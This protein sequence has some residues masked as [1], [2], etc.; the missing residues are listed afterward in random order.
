MPFITTTKT[1]VGLLL[2]VL[3]YLLLSFSTV[4]YLQSS[5]SRNHEAEELEKLAQ[6]L[7]LIRANIEAEVNAELFLADSMATLITFA[8]NAGPTQWEQVAK[9]LVRKGEH[10]RNISVAPND[11]IA[12][13]YPLAGNER[14]IGLD[15]HDNPMQWASIVQARQSQR[16]SISGPLLLVQGG[17][18][19]IGRMPLYFDPPFNTQYWGHCS[20]VIDINGLFKDAGV[21]ELPDNIQIAIRGLNATGASGPV[22]LGDARVFDDP[23]VTESVNLVSGSWLLGL[24]HLDKHQTRPLSKW[25]KDNI[26][27]VAGYC[28][29]ISFLISFIFIYQAYR[30]ANQI[31]LQ[32]V[33][34]KLPNRRYAMMVL[35]QLT[36]AGGR[37]TIINIDLNRFK[38]VN[39]TLGH[40]AGDA[41]LIEVAQ[42]LKQSLRG[43]D[44]VARLGGDEFLIILPRVYSMTE[45]ELVRQKLEQ[46]CL[47]PFTYETTPIEVSLSF[48]VACYP[49]DARDISELLHAADQAMYSEKQRKKS[50]QL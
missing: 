28:I 45:I 34:T 19:V 47:T 1:N 33:L 27:R 14:V 21:F 18:A 40:N 42:R 37:F 41:L 44:T 26:A 11:V 38:L 36:D 6:R 48:G 3:L 43:S 8:P 35:E 24:N 20:V 17:E 5:Y 32:D 12:F 10:I 29:A 7:S 50:Q 39:D 46:A 4:E 30:L 22:F 16:L 15:F 9:L 13:V 31:A 49:Q 25:V 23:L 2:F